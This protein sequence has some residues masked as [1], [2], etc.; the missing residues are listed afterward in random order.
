MSKYQ[1]K[2]FKPFGMTLDKAIAL[3]VLKGIPERGISAQTCEW[4][5]I[6]GEYSEVEGKLVAH[7]FPVTRK[8]SIV[9]FARRELGG[10]KKRS[11]STVG[12]VTVDCELFGAA[13]A[14]SGNKVWVVEGMY[15]YLSLYQVMYND[16]R[17]Q[18]LS[19]PY[20]PSVVSV[21]LGA[22]NAAANMQAN[23]A[24]LTRYKEIITVFDSDNDGQEGVREV[25]LQFP[26]I[27]NVVLDPE[28]KDPNGYL[29][30]GKNK[31]LMDAVFSGEVYQVEQIQRGAGDI[32]EL[33]RP[34]AKGIKIDAFPELMHKLNGL[35]P[36]ELTVLLA[37]PK[38]GKTS[39]CK[40]I[41]YHL[42][43]HKQKAFGIYLEEDI[44]KTRQSFV[45]LDND[46]HLPYF[47]ENPNI[48]SKEAVK[49]TMDTVLNPEWAMFCDSAKGNITPDRVMELLQWAALKGCKYVLLDHLSFIFSGLKSS[50][51]RKEIDKLMTDLAAYVKQTGVHVIAVSHIV[52]DRGR[53]KPK[54]P[55]GTV[56]YPYWY[57]IEDTDGRGS[58]AFAQLCW[59][60]IGIDKQITADRSRGKTR[61]RVLLNR[62]WDRTGMCDVLTLDIHTGKLHAVE[63][64]T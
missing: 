31:Q 19:V 56:K 16:P 51:E 24:F 43:L 20:H 54:N 6:R 26:E 4:F 9:G 7:L 38:T 57:E 39:L 8:G 48:V 41:N 14:K 52:L 40:L 22:G 46:V 42:L 53:P 58:G 61:L 50:D 10:A 1:K 45:A 49:K 34:T 37:P 55:D 36:G 28:L 32:E 64:E 12:D 29:L 11:F 5:G 59:N 33:M 15:D 35:R 47:R 44:R 18:K 62:E 3:P 27:K 63:A 17:N 21:L 2:D 23:T 30:E 25:A 60:M 13:Q